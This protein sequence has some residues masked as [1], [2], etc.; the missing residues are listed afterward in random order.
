MNCKL[1][2]CVITG[3][4]P[5][6]ATTQTRSGAAKKRC[7]GTGR[8]YLESLQRRYIKACAAEQEAKLEKNRLMGLIRQR[9][10]TFGKSRTRCRSKAKTT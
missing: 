3:F 6:P 7:S 8:A 2:E 10:K 9:L 4:N 5:D 1:P